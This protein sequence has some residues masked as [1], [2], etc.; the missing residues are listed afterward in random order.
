MYGKDYSFLIFFFLMVIVI[1]SCSTIVVRVATTVDMC[2]KHGY[3]NSGNH[4]YR[5]EYIG[6]KQNLIKEVLLGSD[7][8]ETKE[9]TG[10]HE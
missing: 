7:E 4:Y 8:N 2:I 6:E 9:D 3:F 10:G 1:T 5:C